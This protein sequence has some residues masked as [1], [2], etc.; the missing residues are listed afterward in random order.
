MDPS[1]RS[2][3]GHSLGTIRVVR[4]AA[5]VGG[6]ADLEPGA[7]GV[8][9][10]D[11]DLTTVDPG[12]AVHDVHPQPGAATH[13][14]LPELGEDPGPDGLVDPLALV[15]DADERPGERVGDPLDADP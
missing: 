1:E 4:S 10:G 11:E 5:V 14:V 15:V 7:A 9:V 8:G 6:P 13:A 2:P 12:Q 3:G